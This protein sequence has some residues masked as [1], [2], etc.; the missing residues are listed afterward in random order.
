MHW[1][2]GWGFAYGIYV[3]IS[4]LVMGNLM[5]RR[6]W[7]GCGFFSWGGGRGEEETPGHVLLSR[8]RRTTRVSKQSFLCYILYI[9]QWGFS[10]QHAPDNRERC[11]QSSRPWEDT[12][13]VK[14]STT[15]R[16]VPHIQDSEGDAAPHS[17]TDS[18]E[19]W[20]WCFIHM[21]FMLHVISVI[22][23]V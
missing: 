10:L 20:V 18:T 13:D 7:V 9:D 8:F 14:T 1:I 19:Q 5:G 16:P 11:P 12:C 17:G 4:T 21:W 6:F 2:Y 3:W 15:R 22:C 23:L